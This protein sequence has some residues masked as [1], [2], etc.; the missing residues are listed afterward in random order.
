[1][2]Q[3]QA[4]LDLFPG[5]EVAQDV[6]TDKDHERQPVGSPMNTP[7]SVPRASEEAQADAEA[8][9]RAWAPS[10]RRTYE[11]AW[12][13]FA[14]WCETNQLPTLPPSANIV[15]GFLEDLVETQDRALATARTYLVGIAATYRLDG[16]PDPTTRPR[17]RATPRRLAREYG[18][19]QRQARGLTSED[20]AAVCATVRMP[21]EY[22]K[23]RV[24]RESKET[25]ERRA[26][27][28]LALIQV[29]RDALLRRS[30]AAA[31]TWGNIEVCSDGTGRLHIARSKTDQEGRGTTR[32]IGPDAIASLLAIQPE[33]ALISSETKVFGLLPG[34]IGRR[35]K[36]ATGAAG[37][38]EGFSGHSGRVG[39]AQ[40]LSADG[41]ELPELM[42]AGRW[43]SPTMPARYTEAQAAG[44]GAVARYYAK[45]KAQQ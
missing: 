2:T 15:V 45:R 31:L 6:Q 10:T 36:A 26:L 44:R 32:Y 3:R 28:D 24:W 12:W 25:A 16:Y 38:G 9:F 41:A 29:M 18:K 34:Q 1:M 42:Q 11:K 20:L 27:V 43:R 21:R 17:V 13:A 5:E 23:G 14:K 33:E 39:M 30:E 4:M 7:L 40:D 19:P 8:E 22:R 35:V 37:L